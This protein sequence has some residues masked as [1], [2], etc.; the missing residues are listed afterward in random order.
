MDRPVGDD[1][2]LIVARQDTLLAA[3][4]VELENRGQE[5]AGV[6]ELVELLE[7]DRN[8]LGLFAAAINDAWNAAFATNRAGGPLAYPAAR[9]G[10]ELLDR[11]HVEY[12]LS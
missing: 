8:R 1:V 6:D 4:D 10:R 11:C 9:H 7:V 2:E 3:V 12:P 5:V